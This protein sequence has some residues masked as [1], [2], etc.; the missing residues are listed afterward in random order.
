MGIFIERFQRVS[1]LHRGELAESAVTDI[2]YPNL[3]TQKFDALVC[4]LRVCS[5]PSCIDSLRCAARLPVKSSEEPK[6]VSAFL[7]TASCPLSA[8]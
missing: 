5:M 6:R 7:A 2:L 8:Y 4:L 3:Q 1:F